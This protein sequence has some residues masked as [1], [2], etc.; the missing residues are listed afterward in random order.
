MFLDMAILF[1]IGIMFRFCKF[2]ICLNEWRSVH[3]CISH[4]FTR[5][6]ICAIAT[7]YV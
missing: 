6:V 7:M 3:V 2:I 1:E 4:V 5:V